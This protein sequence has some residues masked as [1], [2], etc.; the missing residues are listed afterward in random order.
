M[1][2]SFLKLYAPF[3]AIAALQGLFMAVAPSTGPDRDRA[4]DQLTL[5]AGNQGQLQVDE[6]GNV[7]DAEGNIVASA[8]DVASGRFNPAGP[9]AARG[10]GGQDGRPAARQGPGVAGPEGPAGVAGDTSHCTDDGRQHGVLFHAPECKPKWPEGADNGGATYKGV[11][12]EEVLVVSFASRSNEQVNAIL[13]AEGLAQTTEDERLMREAAVE[14]IEKHYELYGRKLKVVRVVGDCPQTPP[15]VAKCKQAAREVAAMKPF[16]VVWATGLYDDV[17]DIWA[18]EGIISLGGWHFADR[19]FNERRPLRWDLNMSGGLTGQA[20]TEYYCTKL[21]GKRASHTG[22][23]IHEDIGARGTVERRL[24][25]ITPAW[26]AKQEAARAVARAVERCSGQPKVPVFTY[27][28]DINKAQDQSRVTVA[29]LIDEKVTTVLCMCDPIAPVFS[30]E[31]MTRNRY[32][33]EHFMGGTEFMDFD[34]VGRLYHPEQWVHAFGLRH[35][36]HPIPHEQSDATKV[37]RD[38]GYHEKTGRS[39]P[40]QSC[41][42]NWAYYSLV[43]S[44]TQNAGPNLNPLTVERG[45]FAGGRRGGWQET[46]GR[47]ELVLVTFGPNDYTAIS[48]FQEVYWSQSAVSAI[49]NRPGAYVATNGNRRYTHGELPRSFDVPVPNR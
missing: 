10:P 18:R 31:A 20:A 41:N 11:T 13:A 40:C 21:A 48:D 39:T 12:G 44:M 35:I 47:P 7:V 34:K 6:Q 5:G 17:F 29:G 1:R 43:A 8:D 24:G 19:M 37:W 33:P 15:D 46:G 38:V 3:I 27:E 9:A 2:S 26:P 25:I 45:M 30:T 22:Q 14:F 32:F 49:D 42:L 28:S 4:S 16:M 36:N 23:L